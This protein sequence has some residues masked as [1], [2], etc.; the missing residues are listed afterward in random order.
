MLSQ[1]PE[2]NAADYAVNVTSQYTGSGSDAFTNY[3]IGALVST[4]I[5]MTLLGAKEFIPGGG[6]SI[7]ELAPSA[8]GFAAEKILGGNLPDAFPVIDKFVDGVATSIKSID[9]TATSYT[10]GNGLLNTIKG[11]VN[12][13]D[14]F[15][16]AQRGRTVIESSDI[17]SKVLEV[18]VQP[19]EA[20]LSQWEQIGKAMQYA[21]DNNLQFNLQFI[22]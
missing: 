8:G 9:L 16:G 21:K 20:S 10:K 3:A 7:W 13:L 1:S 17:T 18:A 19:G 14:D 6:K 15:T 5:A 12:K 22:K 2:Q 4:D 11:Y